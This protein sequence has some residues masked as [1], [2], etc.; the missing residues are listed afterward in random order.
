MYVRS[1]ARRWANPTWAMWSSGFR[2]LEKLP[3]NY[4]RKIGL[5]EYLRFC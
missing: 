4:L 3:V 1:I 5:L 2:S